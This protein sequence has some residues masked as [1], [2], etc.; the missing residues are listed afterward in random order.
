MA[1]LQTAR[2][3]AGGLKADVTVSSS[4]DSATLATTLSTDGVLLAW[5]PLLVTNELQLEKALTLIR[6]KIAEAAAFPPV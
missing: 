2:V 4:A 3:A 5:D 1:T 6:Q